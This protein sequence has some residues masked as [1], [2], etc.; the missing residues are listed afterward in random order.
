MLLQGADGSS[1]S[2]DTLEAAMNDAVS[3]DTLVLQNAVS[4]SNTL[5]LKDGVTLDLNG[6]TGGNASSPCAVT[7]TAS[8]VFRVEAGGS[9]TITN[10]MGFTTVKTSAASVTVVENN[11]TLNLGTNIQLSGGTTPMGSAAVISA[12]AMPPNWRPPCDMWQSQS[13]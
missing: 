4:L 3:G 13:L 6:Q 2:Y 11:G 12:P 5:V 1:R 9:A 7:S 8:P 10:S